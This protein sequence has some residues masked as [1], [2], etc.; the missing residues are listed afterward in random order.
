[1]DG[2][3]L[4]TV[5]AL[6]GLSS[7]AKLR[8]VTLDSCP[9]MELDDV[10]SDDDDDGESSGVP[11]KPAAQP[12]AESSGEYS[13]GSDDGSDEDEEDEEAQKN[14]GAGPAVPSVLHDVINV[15]AEDSV[16][17]FGLHTPTMGNMQLPE[18]TDSNMGVDFGS[19]LVGS[20]ADVAIP[21]IITNPDADEDDEDDEESSNAIG[22]DYLTRDDADISDDVEDGFEPGEDV[23]DIDVE[24]DADEDGPSAAKKAR[25]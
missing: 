17:S 20:I 9:L 25:R 24:D 13:S 1:M 10:D 8:H 11:S 14:A 12:S 18:A 22:L 4:S 16:S 7:L 3:P 21:G 5:A 23:E 19:A 2:N 15:N 6:A